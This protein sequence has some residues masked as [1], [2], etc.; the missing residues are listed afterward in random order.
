MAK[1]DNTTSNASTALHAT[2]FRPAPRFEG[3]LTIL[4]FATLSA[5]LIIQLIF[6]ATRMIALRAR[7]LSA[8]S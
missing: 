3:S 4:L 6:S 8:T 7:T 5:L 1:A 2:S